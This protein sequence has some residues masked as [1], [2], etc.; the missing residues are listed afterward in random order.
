MRV[1]VLVEVEFP[2]RWQLAP[3]ATPFFCVLVPDVLFLM[4]SANLPAWQA[5]KA[6]PA[7]GFPVPRD[8]FVLCVWL[9]GFVLTAD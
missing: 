4:G 6:S 5:V 1:E 8:L 9:F 3:P 7:F 2:V